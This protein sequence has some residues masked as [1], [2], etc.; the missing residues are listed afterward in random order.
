MVLLN[1]E[2]SL[3]ANTSNLHSRKSNYISDSKMSHFSKRNLLKSSEYK[4]HRNFSECNQKD[5]DANE[6]EIWDSSHHITMKKNMSKLRKTRF[7]QK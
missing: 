2:V 3:Y 1:M 6:S 4:I 5:E 7:R